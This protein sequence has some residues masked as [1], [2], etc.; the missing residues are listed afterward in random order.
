MKKNQKTLEDREK[1][2]KTQV[3]SRHK[4]LNTTDVVRDLA[5][6]LFLSEETIWKDFA[7]QKKE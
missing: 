7:K 4:S 2:V 3:N 5:K 6:R 1:Y